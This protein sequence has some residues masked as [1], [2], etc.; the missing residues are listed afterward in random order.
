[1]V[2]NSK[3]RDSA[4][5]I[6]LFII[7]IILT[8]L[9]FL[10]DVLIVFILAALFA[11]LIYPIVQVLDRKLPHVLSIISVYLIIAI[12]LIAIVGLLAPVISNQ[13]REFVDALPNLIAQARD[14]FGNLQERYVNLP[15]RWQS[16]VD[17]A[18]EELQQSAIRITRQTIPAVFALFTGLFALFLVPLIA[19]FM[20]LDYKGYKQMLTAVIP[21]PHKESIDS[22]LACMGQVLRN[23]IK[24]E[25]ILMAT[26][27]TAVGLGL[28][29]VGMPYPA[30]FGVIAGL[31][32]LIPNFG[33][34]VTSIL[35]AIVGLLID[36]VL[37]LKGVGVTIAVQ[38]LENAFLVP[39]VMSKAVGLDPV[40]VAFSIFIGGRISG[41]LGALI[42]IP[43][44]MMIKIVILYFYVKDPR[45]L[46]QQPVTCLVKKRK[47][48]RTRRR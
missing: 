17:G 6:P 18:L 43:L 38:I 47:P 24:G 27:G 44:A 25:F 9:Y 39:I 12:L 1:M 26:V 4:G 48:R 42:A 20:L 14:L 7:A 30:V 41:I 16:L 5:F 34:I 10:W 28:W 8:L 40:T 45:L 33:P 3:A 46:E 2:D 29:L 32:E 19:F 36:P 37:A 13:F 11:F 22:L 15:Q 31:L 21:Q 23:F 35:V